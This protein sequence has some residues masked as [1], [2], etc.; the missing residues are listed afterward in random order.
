MQKLQIGRL[1]SERLILIPYTLQIC[2]NFIINDFTDLDRMGIIKGNG[3]PDLDVMETLPKIVN[4][5]SL[6]E[7]PT[8]F[9]SWMI[10]K[11]DT[12]EIFGD[13]GFKGFN[14][15]EK[16]VDIGYG[17]IER[18]RRKG[19]A[20][21][22]VLTLINWAFLSGIIN[23]ITAECSLDNVSSTKLLE[24]LNFIEKTRSNETLHWTLPNN[25]L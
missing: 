16:N 12:L 17:I 6:V 22:A 2:R 11:K 3:W 23:E 15:L 5:L 1:L 20:V 8:G 18:E 19:Y 21:E 10:I 13:A 9:E 14:Y 25:L 24:K 7:S 4:N